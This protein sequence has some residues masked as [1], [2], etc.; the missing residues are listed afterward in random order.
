MQVCAPCFAATTAVTAAGSA[1]ASWAGKGLNVISRSR[2][3]RS[4]T[5]TPMGTAWRGN[6]FVGRGGPERFVTR[7]S[8]VLCGRYKINNNNELNFIRHK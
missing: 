3:V 7:V 6:V 5:A 4:G 1:T 2:S 8:S